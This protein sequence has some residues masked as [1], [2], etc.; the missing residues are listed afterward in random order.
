MTNRRQSRCEGVIKKSLVLQEKLAERAQ[1]KEIRSLNKTSSSANK[2]S[3]AKDN[4]HL[5][6]DVNVVPNPGV[7]D[8]SEQNS[9][10]EVNLETIEEV[11]QELVDP[12]EAKM[13]ETEY[14]TQYRKVKT[15]ELAVKDSIETFNSKTVSDLDLNTYQ[16][17]L[18]DIGKE[19]KVFVESI[20]DI[21]IDLKDD[22]PRKDD[23]KASKTE[24]LKE[25][26]EN[27]TK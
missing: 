17:S 25:V 4:S 18:K 2:S 15:A 8:S 12:I 20:N 3:A 26:K 23:L 21:L 19:L 11:E 7:I 1:K 9:D 10:K 16:S 27:E 13:D 22:D 14:N 6:A 5:T 24:L